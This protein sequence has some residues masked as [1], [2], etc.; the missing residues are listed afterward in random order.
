MIA[1]LKHLKQDEENIATNIAKLEQN[2]KLLENESVK[3]IKNSIIE[4]NIRNT[5]IKS[6]KDKKETLMEKLKNQ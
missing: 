4:T 6:L 5:Q 2:Q 1:Y 3:G